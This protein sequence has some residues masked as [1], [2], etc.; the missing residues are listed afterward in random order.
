METVKNVKMHQILAKAFLNK[1]KKN[2]GY[3]QRALARD[4][5]TSSAFVTKILTGH[6]N[7][8]PAR[9]KK[10]F[11]I[12]DMD[13]TMQTELMRA[14]VLSA[15]PTNELRVIA[16]ASLAK[17]PAMEKYSREET[18]KFGVLKHWYN[19]AILNYLSCEGLEASVATL[20]KYFKLTNAEVTQALKGLEDAGLAKVENDRWSKTDLHSYFPT[21]K[22]Q[23]EVRDFHRQMIQKAFHELGKS[24]QEDFEKRMISGFTVAVNPEQIETAKKLIA[25]FLGE[26]SEVLSDGICQEVYQCNIQLFPLGNTPR[27]LK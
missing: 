26:I 19:I 17:A 12:L 21:T 1:K 25:D 24:S 16:K 4:L 23:T 7:L 22:S 10:L 9:Y 14:A 18:K 15:L 13:L 20:T 11:K 3:S 6:K 27:G 5:G 8:P 2:P